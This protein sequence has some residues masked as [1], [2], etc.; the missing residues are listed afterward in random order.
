MTHELDDALI[1]RFWPGEDKAEIRRQWDAIKAAMAAPPPSRE[2][3]REGSICDRLRWVGDHKLPL[4]VQLALGEIYA[5][6]AALERTNGIAQEPT[7]AM[8]E[9]GV[10]VFQ[11]AAWQIP[12]SNPK[13]AVERIYLAM[14][15]A[16]IPTPDVVEAL[17]SAREHVEAVALGDGTAAQMVR[18][19]ATLEVIDTA[20]AA[21][22][23]PTKDRQ[24]DRP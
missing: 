2:Y 14:E 13:S 6:A 10:P 3:P 16:R 17:R 18:A 9:A 20:L 21:L 15:A 22:K 5:D 11:R 7:P 4:N 19:G 24:T 8:I 1:E 12:R 23:E